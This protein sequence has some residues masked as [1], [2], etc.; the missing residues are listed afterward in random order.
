MFLIS[1]PDE[2]AVRRFLARQAESA[3][4]YPDVGAS[5][6]G[7]APAGYNVEHKRVLLGSG[8]TAF[9]SAKNAVRAW[10]MFE[11]PWV[12]LY[13]ADTPIEIGRDVAI[14]VDHFGFESMNAARIV[15]LVESEPGMQRFGFA[16]G[17]LPEHG[18]I[19][20]ERFSVEFDEESGE[21][22]Y[23][24][25]AFSRPGAFRL[26]PRPGDCGRVASVTAFCRHFRIKIEGTERF[27]APEV[28][29]DGVLRLDLKRTHRVA[30]QNPRQPRAT[31]KRVRQSGDENVP[32]WDKVNSVGR[33]PT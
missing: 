29:Q 16:Y 3:F 11:M 28:D 18:E 32:E 25:F 8:E 6:Y 10:K 27:D 24:I 20:E 14:V 4:S 23:D 1:R 33:S 5:R 31:A 12:R 26:K 9:E 21:V 17:T 7:K 22:W 30:Q 13:F 2:K 19:G 15:Y